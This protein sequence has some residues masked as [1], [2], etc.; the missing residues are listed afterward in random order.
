[1]NFFKKLIETEREKS[2]SK[3]MFADVDN[4]L[5]MREEQKWEQRRYDLA[6]SI[7]LQERK[8]VVLGKLNSSPEA[9][10]RVARRLADAVIRE[11]RDPSKKMT[12]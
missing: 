7:A 9:I 4:V 2:V 1:M 10:A 8:S 11:L 5:C 6:K 3:P 12:L